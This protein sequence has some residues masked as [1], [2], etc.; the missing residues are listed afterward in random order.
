MLVVPSAPIKLAVQVAVVP[1]IERITVSLFVSEYRGSTANAVVA[2]LANTIS[3]KKIEIKPLIFF[4]IKFLLFIL[5]LYQKT[6]QKEKIRQSNLIC[7]NF[8]QF[9]QVLSLINV[10]LY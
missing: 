3:D 2:K 4:D 1:S 8:Q 7:L 6:A 10:Q 5:P 9:L